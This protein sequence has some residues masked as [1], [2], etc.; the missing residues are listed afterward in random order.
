MNENKALDVLGIK[1]LS[2]S[3]RIATQGLIEGA[4]A[5]LSRLCLPAAEEVGLMLRDK[6]SAWRAGNAIRTLSKANSIYLSNSPSPTDRLSPRLAHVAIEEA[7]WID[8]DQVQAMWSGLLASSTSPDG[9]SDENLL[10]MNLLKQLSSLEVSILRFAVEK[11]RK[12]TGPH[13]L[14]LSQ[15]LNGIPADELPKLFG[16][17]DLHRIDRELDH[18]REL[19]LIGWGGLDTGGIDV[20]TGLTTLTP[21]SLALHLYVRAQ[22]SKLSPVNYWK[23]TLP[24]DE[25]IARKQ[26]R[27]PS[28]E[29]KTQITEQR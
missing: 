22:G 1:G 14:I 18:L 25:N 23:L 20:Q 17:K 9:R 6:V 24:A 3:V 15:P 28:K 13:C 21:T 19:G 11:A 4:G 16:V 27:K 12:F 7:S 29:L 5:F 8:D 26:E 2:D 10:F